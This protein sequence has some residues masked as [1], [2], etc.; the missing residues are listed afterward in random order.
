[1]LFLI[2]LLFIE[3]L[4]SIFDFTSILLGFYPI[5]LIFPPIYAPPQLWENI[6]T[7]ELYIFDNMIDPYDRKVFVTEFYAVQPTL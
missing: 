2:F 5:F 7:E 3:I 6:T 1:M 4:P